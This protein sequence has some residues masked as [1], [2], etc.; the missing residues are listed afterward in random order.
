MA[1]SKF[2][3][4]EYFLVSEPVV[5]Y[6]EMVKVTSSKMVADYLRPFYG[7]LINTKEQF[8]VLYLNRQNL[9]E[10][11]ERHSIGSMFGT[12]CDVSIIAR[13]ALASLSSGVILSHNHPSGNINPSEQDKAITKNIKN[14]L[15]L[16]NIKLMD[17]IILPGNGNSNYYSFSDNSNL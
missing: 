3:L 1:K 6:T 10:G 2:F 5:E 4:K 16:F 12:V 8:I 13:T 14:A 11:I 7:K 17:H 9:I 15:D